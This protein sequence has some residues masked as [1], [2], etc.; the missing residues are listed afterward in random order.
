MA[1]DDR[2]KK[3]SQ[4]SPRV[5]RP[6]ASRGKKGEAHARGE[7]RGGQAGIPEKVPAA[8]P[9]PPPAP[10]KPRASVIGAVKIAWPEGYGVDVAVLLP[11]D[12]RTAFF[13]W[14]VREE[15]MRRPGAGHRGPGE[16]ALRLTEE[17]TGHVLGEGRGVARVGNWYF[18]LSRGGV[19]ASAQVGY[20]LPDGGF[21]V[22]VAS[23]VVKLPRERPGEGVLEGDPSARSIFAELYRLSGGEATSFPRGGASRPL[24]PPPGAG[25]DKP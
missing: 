4:G 23:N 2:G 12:P 15:T 21:L 22:L 10:R 20:P 24:H 19:R 13:Y 1:K 17:G 3:S 25:K 16:L 7:K 9:P 18:H 11:R 8:S 14:E 5:Q 6:S